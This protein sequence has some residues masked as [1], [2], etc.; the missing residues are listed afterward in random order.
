MSTH[1]TTSDLRKLKTMLM[2]LRFIQAASLVAA[3]VNENKQA[4]DYMKEIGRMDKLIELELKEKL[5]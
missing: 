1:L 4:V 5:A 3:G 2:D